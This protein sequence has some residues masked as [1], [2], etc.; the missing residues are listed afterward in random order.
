MN[1]LAELPNLTEMTYRSIKQNV[2]DG[3][4]GLESRLTEEALSTQL[5]ISKS[6]VREAL[7][8]LAAEGLISIEARRGAYLRQFSAKEVADLY[9]LREL[10]EVQSISLAI[11][12]PDL[13]RSLAA[14]ITRTRAQLKAGSKSGHIQEDLV[15]HAL[16]P[17]ATGNEELCRVI[18]NVQHKSLLCHSRSYEL[19]SDSAPTAHLKIYQALRNGTK[20]E[21]RAAMREHIVFVRDRLLA[22]MQAPS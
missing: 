14:S 22:S 4:F 5:G 6:P 12:T 7:N 17:A 20:S 15:F 11:I 8:R 13:L 19:S 10:L 18:E 9:E 3:T 16:I 1:P 21:A 2:L